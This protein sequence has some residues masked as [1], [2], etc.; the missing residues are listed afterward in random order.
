MTPEEIAAAARIVTAWY[1]DE[2]LSPDVFS[3]RKHWHDQLTDVLQT[4]RAELAKLDSATVAERGNDNCL[5][6]AAGESPA[7]SARIS[8]L[9]SAKRWQ[10]AVER[11]FIVWHQV[12]DETDP[13][14]QIC[15]MLAWEHKVALDPTVSPEAA[16]LHGRIAELEAELAWVREALEPFAKAADIKLCG[17]F[18]DSERFGPTDIS[19]HLT[20][21]DLRAARTALK[22]QTHGT[23]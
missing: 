4:A 23:T 1:G 20:F 2:A 17:E 22:D 14:Q 11:W 6:S 16:K 13:Y 10:E 5:I 3:E 21:G 12:P 18:E 19:H 9:E 7:Q 8:E 15:K